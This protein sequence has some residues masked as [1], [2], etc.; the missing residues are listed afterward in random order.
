[1]KRTYVQKMMT[2]WLVF[3]SM[4]LSA[5]GGDW[6][7]FR[8]PNQNGSVDEKGLP[9]VLSIPQN[10]LW[11]AALPG[12]SSA[13]PIVSKG[14]IFLSSTQKG[15]KDLLALCLDAA[16]GKLLWQKILAAASRNPPR[17]TM[18]SSSPAADGQR[19]VFL[20]T[21]GTCTALDYDGNILWSKNLSETFGP[22][23]LKFGYSSSPLIVDGR[24]Y[25]P[26]IRREKPW[27][28][29]TS[30]SYLIALDIQTGDVLFASVRIPR[31][32]DEAKDSYVTPVLVELNGQK[33]IL[34][35]G[36]N[37]ITAHNP[38]TGQTIWEFG[39]EYAKGKYGRAVS[40]PVCDGTQVYYTIP[41]GDFTVAVR[42]DKTGQLSPACRTWLF[43]QTGADCANPL[44]YKDL[45]YLIDDSVEK[46]MYCIQARD[47]KLIWKDKLPAKGPIFA[48]PTAADD[49]IYILDESGKV[50]IV[51]AGGQKMNLLSTLELGGKPAYSTIAVANECLF[52][53]TAE[54]IYCFRE[55]K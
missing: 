18:A 45:L 46:T 40:S 20:Y 37:C 4:T 31:T 26:L 54:K 29:M 9:A 43:E 24:V 1:M 19:V 34:L 16:S 50:M 2:C 33:Q 7:G 51:A 10:L 32:T 35:A 41:H 36:A 8:G 49:K 14:R 48:S 47:G 17:N 3:M 44:L 6:A 55:I 38:A 25:I 11:S 39:Y 21:D 15:G 42:P 30:D 23:S 12:E 52:V 22:F 5:F 13:T 27:S 53:R 28:S